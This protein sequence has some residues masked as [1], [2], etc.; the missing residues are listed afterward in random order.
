MHLYLGPVTFGWNLSQLFCIATPHEYSCNLFSLIFRVVDSWWRRK[1]FRQSTAIPLALYQEG[2]LLST[3]NSFSIPGHHTTHMIIT[4]PHFWE[5]SEWVLASLWRQLSIRFK[6]K[7]RQETPFE[8]LHEKM[9]SGLKKVPPG[10]VIFYYFE[11]WHP[12]CFTITLT[13]YNY[14]ISLT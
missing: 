11:E 14:K 7:I 3:R 5:F 13:R 1:P 4:E 8:C 6:K 2:G 10:R 9:N 12:G